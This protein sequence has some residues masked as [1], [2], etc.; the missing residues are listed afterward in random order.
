MA[1]SVATP[2]GTLL[3]DLT[4]RLASSAVESAATWPDSCLSAPTSA[5]LWPAS[6]ATPE[7][8]ISAASPA[9]LFCGSSASTRTFLLRPSGSARFAAATMLAQLGLSGPSSLATEDLAVAS[10]TGELA[11]E[12]A[13]SGTSTCGEDRLLSWLSTRLESGTQASPV[14][15]P[16]ATALAAFTEVS[17]ATVTSTHLLSIE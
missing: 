2:I 16:A 7:A 3:P 15:L 11:I 1:C 14:N 17:L 5:L 4:V 8:A 12:P 10:T 9:E 6:L 13:G